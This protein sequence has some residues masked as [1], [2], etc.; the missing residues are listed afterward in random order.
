M[1]TAKYEVGL[2]VWYNAN[3]SRHEGEIAEVKKREHGFFY[4]VGNDWVP[5]EQLLPIDVTL[6]TGIDDSQTR[7]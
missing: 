2:K 6:G 7:P 3:W 4:R 1:K 5:Q